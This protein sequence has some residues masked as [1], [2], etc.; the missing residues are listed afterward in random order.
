MGGCVTNVR[1]AKYAH[2][3]VKYCT[4]L[5]I[6]SKGKGSVHLS[7]DY[8][9]GIEEYPSSTSQF[10]FTKNT[11]VHFSP[12]SDKNA[13]SLSKFC[14]NELTPQDEHIRESS[15]KFAAENW[16]M[17]KKREGSLTNTLEDKST[18]TENSAEECSSVRK[19]EM[20][21]YPANRQSHILGFEFTDLFPEVD[22]QLMISAKTDNPEVKADASKIFDLVTDF[23]KLKGSNK[24]QLAQTWNKSQDQNICDK[25][26]ILGIP[27]EL[28]G[29]PKF[30]YPFD[31]WPASGDG[32]QTLPKGDF[33]LSGFDTGASEIIRGVSDNVRG[34]GE[35]IWSLRSFEYREKMKTSDIDMFELSQE[36]LILNRLKSTKMFGFLENMPSLTQSLATTSRANLKESSIWGCDKILEELWEDSGLKSLISKIDELD[37]KI[38]KSTQKLTELRRRSLS[39]LTDG[40]YSG[41]FDL[42]GKKISFVSAEKEIIRWQDHKKKLVEER[43]RIITMLHKITSTPIIYSPKKSEFSRL[44]DTTKITER[45][46]EIPSNFI[47][48]NSITESLSSVSNLCLTDIIAEA[49]LSG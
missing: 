15:L 6:S 21:L 1:S 37:V 16:P 8:I 31:S 18:S 24:L 46:I 29:D 14:I 4:M 44:G 25:K 33:E 47:R 30:Y 49:D 35:T 10:T 3:L 45:D 11:G 13:L 20:E 27:C 43:N 2:P 9:E 40:C 19:I 38:C 36:Q 28:G 32:E 48:S 26:N 34:S 12:T 7:I 23:P 17:K 5:E 39:I 22:E 41:S 42:S